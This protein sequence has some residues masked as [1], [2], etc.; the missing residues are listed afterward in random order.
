MN[1]S[2]RDGEQWSKESSS[3]MDGNN[4]EGIMD[5]VFRGR[6]RRDSR[7]TPSIKSVRKQQFSRHTGWGRARAWS[8][9]QFIH[10]PVSPPSL[11]SKATTPPLWPGPHAL[12]TFQGL[13]CTAALFSSMSLAFPVAPGSVVH[14]AHATPAFLF[15][16]WSLLY[17]RAQLGL[18]PSYLPGCPFYLSSSPHLPAPEHWNIL[19]I[20]P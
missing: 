20:S 12:C 5:N 7:G 19:E 9:H 14:P 15:D 13:G 11:L 10:H 17:S 3:E 2:A 6:G 16:P 18:V 1:S 8:Y 4:T